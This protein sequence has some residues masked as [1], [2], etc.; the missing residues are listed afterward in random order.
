[1]VPE[2]E[3]PSPLVTSHSRFSAVSRLRQISVPMRSATIV[4]PLGDGE[5]SLDVFR[6]AIERRLEIG[7]GHSPCDQPVEDARPSLFRLLEVLDTRLEVPEVGIDRTKRHTDTM[8]HLP[9]CTRS[10]FR[11]VQ[12]P[13]LTILTR[14]RSTDIG[15]SGAGILTMN[16]GFSL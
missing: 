11:S 16:S 9:S 8:S 2:A 13:L 12:A 4:L 3:P 6:P 7:E 5:K 10:T 1:T 15:R 14:S